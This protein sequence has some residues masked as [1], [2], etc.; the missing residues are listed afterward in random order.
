VQLIATGALHASAEAMY[1]LRA[2]QEAISHAPEPRAK[3]CFAEPPKHSCRPQGQMV[4]YS[5]GEPVG[6][7]LGRKELGRKDL[8]RS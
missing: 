3:R 2:T 1:P 7:D 5:G 8:R 4:G 6:I